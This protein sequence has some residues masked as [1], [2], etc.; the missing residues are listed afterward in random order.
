MRILHP[1]YCNPRCRVVLPRRTHIL[2]LHNIEQLLPP[3]STQSSR[4]RKSYEVHQ[5][6][7]KSRTGSRR[8]QKLNPEGIRDSA[9][10][11]SAW[12]GIPLVFLFVN[13]RCRIPI[14]CNIIGGCVTDMGQ[15]FHRFANSSAGKY[16]QAEKRHAM[17]I[18]RRKN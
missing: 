18:R 6:G 10:V 13:R 9:P 12:F 8:W 4:L 11:Y 7:S 3:S 16:Q 1:I 14:P 5:L 15:G 17:T 2:A